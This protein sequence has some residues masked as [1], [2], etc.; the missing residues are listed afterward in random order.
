MK[1]RIEI[2]EKIKRKK[3]VIWDFD[4]VIKDSVDIKGKVFN[5]LFID[6]EQNIKDKILNLYHRKK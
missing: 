5:K 3:S 2:L 1:D 6:Q 4:G